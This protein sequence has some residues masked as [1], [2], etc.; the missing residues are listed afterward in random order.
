[1]MPSAT[2]SED[3]EREYNL[4]A[5][6]P[7]YVVFFEDWRKRSQEARD[8]ISCMIDV[9]YGPGP[10]ERVDFFP[11]LSQPAPFLVFIHGGYWR[12]MDKLDFSFL[13]DPFVRRGV[14]LALLNYDL[15][16]GTTMSQLVAQV[17]R[18]YAW[19]AEN[20]TRFGVIPSLIHLAGWSAGAH[21]AAMVL[22]STRA[23]PIA[24]LL[25]ISGVYD[26]MPILQ[27]EANSDLRLDNYDA[28]GNSP[29]RLLPTNKQ[30]PASIIWGADET[31]AFRKQSSD[32]VSVWSG[33]GIDVR[34]LEVEKLHHYAV[35]N[36]LADE[37][38]P[39]FGESV[40]L[41]RS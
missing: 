23:I 38:G 25:A 32:L 20:A 9:P 18:A 36:A 28:E 26:L 31:L 12:S 11:A 1:M 16:P 13:A 29:L 30:C 6:F 33:H 39:V 40:R 27:T 24:S 7:D 4:R 2:V 34:S 35:M 22:C 15:F 21:L 10:R 41:L 37:S 5:A 14:S 8:R 19:V 17:R 3:I